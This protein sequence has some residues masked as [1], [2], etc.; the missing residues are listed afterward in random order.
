MTAATGKP[1]RVGLYREILARLSDEDLA[2][3]KTSR[4]E[5]SGEIDEIDRREPMPGGNTNTWLSVR[6]RIAI[7]T[8]SRRISLS[9]RGRWA[10]PAIPSANCRSTGTTTG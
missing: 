1:E 4:A 7:T 2:S 3:W 9:V 5:L 6:A 8:K 10:M